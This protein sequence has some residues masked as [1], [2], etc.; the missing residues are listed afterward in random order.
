MMPEKS[1]VKF[2]HYTCCVTPKRVTSW[3]CS[4]PRHNAKTT[5]LLAYRCW[6]GGE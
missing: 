1:T 4:S 2:F 3:W 6:S 5:Q